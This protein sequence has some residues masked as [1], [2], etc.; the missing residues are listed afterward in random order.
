MG[1]LKKGYAR[2]GLAAFFIAVC[3]VTVPG[4]GILSITNPEGEKGGSEESSDREREDGQ[5][6][7]ELTQRQKELLE[8]MGLPADYDALTI[9]QKNAI[10]SIEA[11]L[12]YLE[13]KYGETFCYLSYAEAGALEEEHLKAYPASGSPAD[14][15]T[16]YRSY[17]DGTYHYKDDYGNLQIRALY[18][19]KVKEFASQTFQETGIKVYSEIRDSGQ[20]AAERE[21]TEE[22][23]LQSVSALTYIFIS[24]GSCTMAEFDD[25]TEQCAQWLG[26]NCKGAAS[27]ICL[28]LT[29]K[30]Q[31]EKID[32]YSYE[33]SLRND[34]FTAESE[35]AVSVSGKVTVY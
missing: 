1:I 29:E 5:M 26:D 2:R 19:N 35:C 9:T 32:E 6:N 33:D 15:V 18:E 10:V 21:M 13:D 17:E 11:L 25:F 12:T 30:E 8:E 34:I 4:C 20:S 27:Q 7:I 3:I 24:D 23:I 31:W 22:N 28:R 16:V 14:V